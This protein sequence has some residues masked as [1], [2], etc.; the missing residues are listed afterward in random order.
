MHWENQNKQNLLMVDDLDDDVCGDEVDDD[1]LADD[2]DDKKSISSEGSCQ[3]LPIEVP[4]QKQLNNHQS[5]S[6][7]WQMFEF[8]QTLKEL[9][10]AESV[11][12]ILGTGQFDGGFDRNLSLK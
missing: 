6:D 9:P 4:Q 7:I 10:N 8:D 12:D 2:E 1:D 3:G 11:L 5:D